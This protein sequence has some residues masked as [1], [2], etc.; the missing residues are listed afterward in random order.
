[1]TEISLILF[2]LIY[3]FLFFFFLGVE[4][5]GYPCSPSRGLIASSTPSP[6][7]VNLQNRRWSEFGG[8]V[9]NPSPTAQQQFVRSAS[10]RLSRQVGAS[11]ATPEG[12][13]PVSEAREGEKKFQQVYT[14]LFNLFFFFLM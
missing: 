6:Y 1:M 13:S 14:V 4:M 11:P 7:Q 2:N 12:I 3:N 5:V 10:A 8:A 9:E